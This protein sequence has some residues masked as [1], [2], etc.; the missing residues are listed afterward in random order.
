MRPHPQ[1]EKMRLHSTEA[2]AALV[3]VYAVVAF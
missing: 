3:S 2:A 1:P